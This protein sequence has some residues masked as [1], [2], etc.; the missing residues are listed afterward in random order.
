MKPATRS[1][2]GAAMEVRK[3]VS[4]G[5][6]KATAAGSG[7]GLQQQAGTIQ[8]QPRALDGRFT[9][10]GSQVTA[11]VQAK[12]LVA[13]AV[14]CGSR[15]A[16]VDSGRS[17]HL[18]AAAE[19]E[20]DLDSEQQIS[21]DG[22]E[23]SSHESEGCE[24]SS[25]FSDSGNEEDEVLEETGYQNPIL[26]S[27]GGKMADQL[28]DE[29][30]NPAPVAADANLGGVSSEKGEVNGLKTPWVNLFKDNRYGG[31]G[32]KLEEVVVDGD[33]VQLDEEDVGEVEEAVGICLV[34]LFSGK[35]PGAGA[36]RRLWDAW[37]V[38]G[39]FWIHRSGWILFEFCSKEDRMRVLNGGPYFIYGSNLM[40]KILPRCFRFGSEVMTTVST[41]IQLPDL[42]L[43]CWNN[44]ALS[45]IVSKVGTPIS[46]DQLT[47]TIDRISFARVLV[48]VDVS[49]ELVTSV[50]VKLPTGVVYD[51]LVVF[52][53]PPKY[54]KKC[55]TF[56]HGDAGC[57]R[58]S[59]E[60]IYLPYVPKRKVRTG[61]A[62]ISAA[63]CKKGGVPPV[64]RPMAPT[65]AVVQSSTAG[66]MGEVQGAVVQ[67]VGV[68]H[69]DGGAN[70]S[71]GGLGLSVDD[72]GLVTHAPALSPPAVGRPAMAGLA[73][74]LVDGATS[75]KN[76]KQV[77]A[78]GQPVV[79]VVHHLSVDGGRRLESQ[80][81]VEVGMARPLSCTDEGLGVSSGGWKVVGKKKGKRR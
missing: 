75:G 52:E 29:L 2:S 42:P 27:V 7:R 58:V 40:L 16:A 8:G 60:R 18:Q 22:N 69:E 5:G 66:V 55:L 33:L 81:E 50:K 59:G 71:G 11:P 6:S 15:D 47:R 10:G 12:K 63:G 14:Q 13:V 35:F 4:K 51:Q 38:K 34:G 37:K 54:C 65:A 67:P 24:S 3:G 30:P 9:K 23:V 39:K 32:Y 26:S 57:S 70:I 72:A 21:E 73:D 48:E 45:K 19:Q 36:V 74:S 76:R 80:K 1:C 78:S 43:E 77:I 61:R 44:L 31:D 68:F 62:D 41:W 64:D 79:P 53:S 56:T 28:F 17:P 25:A 49:K 46:S 20:E